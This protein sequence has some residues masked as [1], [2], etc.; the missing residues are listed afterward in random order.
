MIKKHK[1]AVAI[2][3][4]LAISLNCQAQNIF[5]SSSNKSLSQFISENKNPEIDNRQIHAS[6][7]SNVNSDLIHFWDDLKSDVFDSICKNAE[8]K[9]NQDAKLVDTFGI[10]GK[11][12]RYL[13]Q[14]PNKKIALIDEVGVKLDATLGKEVL[15]TPDLGP[16]NVAIGASIEGKSIVVKPLESDKYCKELD[17]LIDLREV[18]TIL[19]INARRISAMKEGEI[20]KMPITTRFSF[21]TGASAQVA[22][23]VNVFI[24]AQTT[25]ERKPSVTLFRMDKNTI[26]LRIRIDRLLVKSVSA[27]VSSTFE[28]PA[29][30]IGL[31]QAENILTR[32]INKQLAREINKYLA[33]KI[34]YGHSRNSGRKILIEFLINPNDQKQLDALVEFLR[35]DLGV[36]KRFIELGLKF[37]EFN[38]E[39]NAFE[40]NEAMSQVIDQAQNAL[41]VDASFAGANH[42]H[43][44]SDNLNIVVPV[45]HNHENSWTSSYNRYQTINKKDGVMHVTQTGRVSNGSSINI[46]FVGTLIKYNSEK[47]VYVINKED[48]NNKVSDPA[49]LFQHNVG[50]VR[51]GE[52]V[53]RDIIHRI[54]N[55]L[56]YA[57]VNGEGVSDDL[58]LP[59]DDIFPE[60]PL[61]ENYDPI[62]DA[63]PSKTYKASVVSFKLMFS[64]E[65]IRQVITAPLENILK[66]YLNVMKESESSL[67]SKVAH[68]F[69]INSKNIVEYDYRKAS[70]ILGADTFYQGSD[71]VNPLDIMRDMAYTATCFIKDIISVR[72]EGNF[73]KQSEKLS[74]IAAGRGKSKMGF[75]DFFKVAIQ[76][77]SK[78]NISAEVYI[79][80]D[81]RIKDEKDVTETYSYANNK[82]NSYNVTMEEINAMRERFSDPSILSD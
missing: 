71:G 11:F 48:E 49:L 23:Y 50:F 13:R 81:K 78:N 21:S 8:I 15:Q 37:N 56:K 60:S 34:V 45:I 55:V 19:P 51:Q 7:V 82:D 10:E 33:A 6:T 4:L 30:D 17:M 20:W 42:Y 29:S 22:S 2:F 43:G 32:E 25:K 76:L 80:T 69:K 38:E 24:G 73:K 28:I 3:S 63:K 61:P 14:F 65:G 67:L 52:G 58:L 16:V 54:N 39:A 62:N 66:A 31:F 77:V 57:G 36:I 72:D 12:K 53:A 68:L 5:D 75:E 35:G 9:L 26:R 64:K 46:P 40:G 79:H 27:G 41:G 59:V 18:K 70:E 47:N 74:A 44:H 1:T